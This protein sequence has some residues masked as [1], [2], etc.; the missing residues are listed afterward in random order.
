M[1]PLSGGSQTRPDR[2]PAP[3]GH[4]GGVRSLAFSPDGSHLATASSDG[5]LKVWDV[6]TGQPA[7]T[8]QEPK[9]GLFSS[10]EAFS[11]DGT[12]VAATCP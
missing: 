6:A 7:R 12:R 10:C 5:T 4:A 8:L 9:D 3:R 11:P 2:S 1:R